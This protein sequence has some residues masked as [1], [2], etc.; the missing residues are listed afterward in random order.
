M[1]ETWLPYLPLFLK[2]AGL[3]IWLSWLALMVGAI[4]GTLVAFGRMSKW[5][6]LRMLALVF[7]ELFR[8]IPILIVLFFAYFGLPLI[9]GFDVST[10]LAATLALSLH[11]TATMSE[12]VRAGIASVGKGQW[13]SA[14]ASGMTYAQTMRHVVGPQAL[15]V[16]LPPS[17][18]VYITTIKESSLASII[19]YVELTKTGLLIRESE[20]GGFVPLL[21]LAFLYFLINYGISLIGAYFE[22]RTSVSTKLMIAGAGQ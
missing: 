8:S 19:G 1:I 14:R 2:A 18:G 5:W 21:I 15:Q 3:T 12:V 7:T 9:T 4:A 11:A 17:V 22:R 10:F 13:E 6:P 20:G 16:I